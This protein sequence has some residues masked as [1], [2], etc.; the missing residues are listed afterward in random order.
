MTIADIVSAY[1]KLEIK[2]LWDPELHGVQTVQQ[3]SVS[4]GEIVVL[5]VLLEGQLM[6]DTRFQVHGCGYMI[7]VCVWL[8]KWLQGRALSDCK[9]FSYQDVIQALKLPKQKYHCAILAEDLVKQLI[10]A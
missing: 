4:S 2:P 8:S 3:G 5:Q 6:T 1:Q 10:A 9:I 7:A